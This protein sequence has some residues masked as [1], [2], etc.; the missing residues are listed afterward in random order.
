[1]DTSARQQ[2]F[3]VFFMKNKTDITIQTLVKKKRELL[4]QLLDQSIQSVILNSNPDQI[5]EKRKQILADLYKNETCIKTREKQT[6]IDSKIQEQNLYHDVYT[7]IHSINENNQ[8][9]II[10]IESEK[11]KLKSE[12][13]ELKNSAR[14]SGYINQSKSYQSFKPSGSSPGRNPMKNHLVKGTY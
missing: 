2:R 8:Q 11:N 12:K 7:L 13:H 9:A 10:R 14:L 4:R 1:M 3:L 5:F 6:N